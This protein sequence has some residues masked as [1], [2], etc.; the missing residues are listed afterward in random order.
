MKGMYTLV[1]VIHFWNITQNEKNKKTKKKTKKQKQK[2][3]KAS[4]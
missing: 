2:N 3:K 1:K 4:S